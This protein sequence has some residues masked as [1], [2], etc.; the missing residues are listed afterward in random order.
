MS[1]YVPPVSYQG[2]VAG[3]LRYPEAGNLLFIRKHGINY[4]KSID[5][6]YILKE[7]G[8]K[9]MHKW[10]NFQ[11]AIIFLCL[12]LLIFLSPYMNLYLENRYGLDILQLSV[13]LSI[14]EIIPVFTNIIFSKATQ[15]VPIGKIIFSCLILDAV[16][17]A[18]LALVNVLY[19]QIIVIIVATAIT[20]F[21]FPLISMYIMKEFNEKYRGRISGYVNFWY[22]LGDSVG[23][24]S[25]GILI[26]KG[27]FGISF[28]IA[29][30]LFLMVAVIVKGWKK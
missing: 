10:N 18:V 19:I 29:S 27:L 8:E 3:R 22:N 17:Y 12:G 28:G 4:R 16:L 1:V 14:L 30:F 24:Y 13:F 26:K 2:L 20:S 21:V 25:E 6:E 15:K 11:I 7:T 23:T 9:K 5:K